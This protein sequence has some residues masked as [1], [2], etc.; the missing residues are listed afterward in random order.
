MQ[1]PNI[2]LS[3]PGSKEAYTSTLFVQ[4]DLP[5]YPRQ[6]AQWRGMVS[7]SAGWSNDLFHNHQNSDAHQYIFRYPLIQY[8]SVRGKAALWAIGPGVEAVRQWVGHNGKIKTRNE[9]VISLRIIDL[10]EQQH[11]LQMTD[12]LQTYRLMDWI[13]L[14]EANYQRWKNTDTL[15]GRVRLLDEI[16]AGQLLGFATALHWQLPQRLEAR[17]LNLKKMRTVKLHDFQAIAFNVLYRTNLMLP[18]AIALGR[19]KAFGFGVQAPV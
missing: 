14:N 8:R 12:S 1:Q 19:G 11:R 5:L 3:K 6:I 9:S 18:T 16:L 7:E 10:L 17:L 4:F 15:V 13:A 2:Q